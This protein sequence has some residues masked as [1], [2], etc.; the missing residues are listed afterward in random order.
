VKRP[1]LT[2][3]ARYWFDSIM[4]R[5]TISLMGLLA[6]ASAA[7]IL[8]ITA[9]VV[10]FRL[11]PTRLP[12]GFT[13]LGPEEILWG[14][15]VRVL[16][17]GSFREDEGWGFRIAMLVVTIAGLILVASL[18]GIVSSAFDRRLLELRKGRSRVLETG[19]TVILGWSG[20]VVPIVAELQLA[21]R[22]GARAAI[23]VLSPRDKVAV[24]D[25]LRVRIPRQ[26][27][28]RII[29]RSGDPMDP[30]DL[31]MASPDSARSIIV[32]APDAATEPDIEVIKTVLAIGRTG[33]TAAIIGELRSE[34][35]RAAAELAG[36]DRANWIIGDEL[37]GRLTLH[38][39]RHDGIS[40]VSRDLLD[41]DG[42]E[43]HIARR[44][45]LHGARFAEAQRRFAAATLVGLVRDGAVQLNPAGETELQPDDELVLIAADERS[46][47]VGPAAPVQHDRIA[48]MRPRDESPSRTLMLGHHAGMRSLLASMHAFFPPG[49]T[50]HLVSTEPLDDE[51]PLP[52]VTRQQADTTSRAVLD[53]LD[54]PTF[55]H[56][57]VVPYK[58]VLS[59]H[60]ADA[61]TL[62]TL[63]HL[64]DIRQRTSA[65]FSVVTEMLDDRNGEVLEIDSADDVIVSDLLVSRVL[66]QVSMTPRLVDV[67]DQLFGHLGSETHL[68]PIDQYLT[69]G[70]PVR[71]ATLIEAA[72]RRGETFVGY[73]VAARRHVRPDFGVVINPS[74][75][76]QVNVA[77]DDRLIVLA[78]R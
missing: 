31:A 3:R 22:D 23:V 43:F 38:S 56:V 30:T 15:L 9:I 63:L 24:E 40:V 44:P 11:Y 49:S 20:K 37:I 70:G 65:G 17:A 64:R 35:N 45:E 2:E 41:F 32:L 61:R 14:S 77:P 48:T 27:G 66:A 28:T 5:G 18:I 57:V 1:T 34:A 74:S 7:F 54:L 67:F 4:A 16:S 47:T 55:D 33:S 59:R 8:A 75:S 51:R 42:D 58:D 26:R 36:G 50:T 71:V 13:S 76:W 39:V 52:H 72:S 21:Q 69:D 78:D 46:L 60:S 29:V 53:E 73:R 25:E 12:D 19:H 10:V 6:I 62:V 68:R